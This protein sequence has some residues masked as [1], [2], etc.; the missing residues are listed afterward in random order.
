M[1]ASYRKKPSF[2]ALNVNEAQRLGVVRKRK[3][4]NK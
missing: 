2:D 3:R 4:A 1:V